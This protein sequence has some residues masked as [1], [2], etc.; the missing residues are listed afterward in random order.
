M[1]AIFGAFG[2]G[3]G[4][5]VAMRDTRASADPEPAAAVW[6]AEGNDTRVQLLDVTLPDCLGDLAGTSWSPPMFMLPWTDDHE[7]PLP[8]T[9]NRGTT[10]LDYAGF[11][12]GDTPLLV[13]IHVLW[14]ATVSGDGQVVSD[15]QAGRIV[16]HF[17]A[18]ADHVPLCGVEVPFV[19]Q[20]PLQA[21]DG[22]GSVQ[23]AS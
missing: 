15:L 12:V 19:R 3:F 18:G 7:G 20:T 21:S 1:A 9:G 2:L 17:M 4:V 14:N 11:T 23:D 8:W 6:V 10:Y 5:A 13:H 22:A 16:A